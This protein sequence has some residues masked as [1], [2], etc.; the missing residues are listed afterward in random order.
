MPRP[1][2]DPQ[3]PPGAPATLLADGRVLLASGGPDLRPGHRRFA[4]R[5]ERPPRRILREPSP[6]SSAER[7]CSWAEALPLPRS[8]IPRWARG[9]PR[10]RWPRVVPA[11]PPPCFPMV[12]SSW[13]GA[14]MG[15]SRR[16]LAEVYNP[17]IGTWSPTG[18]LATPRLDHTASLLPDGR[19]LV[20]GGISTFASPSSGAQT[21]LGT[22]E[23]YDPATGAWTSTGALTDPRADAHG[24]RPDR[25]P[26]A[27]GRRHE[28]LRHPRRRT[29]ER[30]DLRP[31]DRH[32]DAHG[33]HD[34]SARGSLRDP[35]PERQGARGGSVT[36]E[37]TSGGVPKTNPIE[38]FDPAT[39]AFSLELIPPVPP[40]TFAGEVSTCRRIGAA[41]TLLPNGNVLVSGGD[42]IFPCPDQTYAP[43]HGTLARRPRILSTSGSLAFG[44][45]FSVTGSRF[46]GDSEAGSG[47]TQQLGRELS[48][49]PGSIDRERPDARGSCPTRAP[50]WATSP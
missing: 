23:I 17:T 5:R 22:A 9:R 41:L 8:T 44:S 33:G 48:P 40:A 11:T 3:L 37:D 4:S 26:S 28:Q 27:R 16:A 21:F 20:A 45:A 7:C 35:P 12:A 15:R 2:P 32:V 42:N 47:T 19:V 34:H 50:T 30:R 1:F 14:A 29:P 31:R 25:W 43:D 18:P 46:R 38:I 49:G 39:G 6:C 24:D 13:P 36:S 10:A